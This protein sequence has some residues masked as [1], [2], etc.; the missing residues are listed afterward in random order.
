MDLDDEE[1]EATR[2]LNGVDKEINIEELKK[3]LQLW[4][5]KWKQEREVANNKEE[6]IK[7]TS[8]IFLAQWIINSK[9]GYAVDITKILR[10]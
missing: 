2:K 4:I 7:L 3:A 10:E 8:E 5:E 6:R 9:R 1:L